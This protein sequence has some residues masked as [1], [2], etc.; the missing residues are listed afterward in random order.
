[1]NGRDVGERFS[2]GKREGVGM[3]KSHLVMVKASI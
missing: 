1:M 3:R 2:M